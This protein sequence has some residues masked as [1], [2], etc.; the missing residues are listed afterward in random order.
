MKLY[1]PWILSNPEDC[2]REVV[3]SLKKCAELW[4]TWGLERTLGSSISVDA[5][6]CKVKEPAKSIKLL[7]DLDELSFQ[8]HVFDH[9]SVVCELSLLPVDKLQGMPEKF[10]DWN[11][12]L[13]KSCSP[14]IIVIFH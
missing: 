7:Y 1:K 12:L 10:E 6:D 13:S 5:I 4:A 9:D 3:S 2:S 14:S 11:S 8:N